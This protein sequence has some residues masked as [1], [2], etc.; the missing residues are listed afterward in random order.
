[1]NDE[2][3]TRSLYNPTLKDIETDFDLNGDNPQ[4]FVLKAGEIKEYPTYIAD[5]LE[6]KLVERMLWENVPSNKNLNKRRS[7]LR[8]IIRV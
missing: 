7:E 1:M 6:D 4:H 3:P 2:K 5:L 8:E